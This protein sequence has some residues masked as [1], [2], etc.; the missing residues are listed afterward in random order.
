M[1]KDFQKWHKE[2]SGL[3]NDKVRPFFHEQEVWFASIGVNVGFEQDGVGEKFLSP[4][5]IF[6]KFSN[7][8]CWAVPTT[9]KNKKGIYYFRF[10]WRKNKSS[11]VI[12]SQIR[13]VDGK[14]LFYRVGIMNDKDFKEMKKRLISFLK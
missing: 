2:K 8:V 7:E 12:L 9:K 14:R 5:V 10:N 13:L 6:K 11:S 3:H 4:V 1:K